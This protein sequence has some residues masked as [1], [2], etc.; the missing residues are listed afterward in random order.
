MPPPGYH[1]LPRCLDRRRGAGLPIPAQEAS[2]GLPE[3]LP[4]LLDVLYA[5]QQVLVGKRTGRRGVNI[6]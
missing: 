3:H 4:H 6:S 5:Q 1:P 2:P